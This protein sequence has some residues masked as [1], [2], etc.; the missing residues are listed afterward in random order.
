MDDKRLR[1]K[2]NDRIVCKYRNFWIPKFQMVNLYLHSTK[3]LIVILF[4]IMDHNELR[5]I[6]S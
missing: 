4:G 1:K 6:N 5:H 3:F 2:R